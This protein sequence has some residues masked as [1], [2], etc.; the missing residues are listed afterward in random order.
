MK[1]AIYLTFS[2]AYISSEQSFAAKRHDFERE[3][4]SHSTRDRGG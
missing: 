3:K 1:T 2:H 4:T